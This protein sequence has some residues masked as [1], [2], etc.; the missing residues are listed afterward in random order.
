MRGDDMNT[1]FIEIR[2]YIARGDLQKALWTLSEIAR[3]QLSHHE[4][5][6]L[7]QRAKVEEVFRKERQ[8]TLNP[9]NIQIRK[10]QVSTAIL[11]LIDI[12]EQELINR[13]EKT[14]SN[15]E[16]TVILVLTANPSETTEIRIDIEIREIRTAILKAQFHDSFNLQQAHAVRVNDLHDL[17]LYHKPQIVHF[18]GHGSSAG[19]IILE[20]VAREDQQNLREIELKGTKNRV[21]KNS[22]HVSAQA[23]GKT[24]AALKH[25]GVRCVVLNACYSQKQA[26][27]IAE[28][29]GC[30]IGMSKAIGD[31]SA[32]SFATS[33]Y[34]ALA[35]GENLQTAF[36]LGKAE[37]DLEGLGEEDTPK[38]LC[39]NSNPS[40]I[41]FVKN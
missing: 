40:E 12:M 29:V 17:L 41:V 36:E 39:R 6:I 28:H 27:A 1:S 20:N 21:I 22:G 16:K 26:E 5:E 30:V 38:I 31:S 11:E 4:N 25:Y 33:F 2:D 9:D 3:G 19:E 32:I 10:S 37:I 14:S 24:F 7:L 18:S 23:L 13:T 35:Y 8:G 34:R 15:S